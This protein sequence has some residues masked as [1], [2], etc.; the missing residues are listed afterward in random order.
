MSDCS[1]AEGPTADWPSASRRRASV[2]QRG[3]L[4]WLRAWSGAGAALVC[5]AVALTPT[6]RAQGASVE[7]L[8]AHCGGGLGLPPSLGVSEPLR[9]GG[10]ATLMARNL[11]A[12]SSGFLLTGWASDRWNSLPL[13]WSL[14]SVGMVGCDLR[15]RPDDIEPF[16]SPNS[17]AQWPLA[18]PNLPSL[19]G[20]HYYAQVLF[21]DPGANPAGFG[22]TPGLGMR[23]EPPFAV[24][25]LQS[26]V[27]KDGITFVFAQPTRVGRFVNGDWFTVGPAR[28][29]D[30]LP[31]ATNLAGRDLHGAMVDPAASV[32]AQGFDTH[33]YGAANAQHYQ[34]GLNRAL[35]VSAQTPLVLMPGH[36]LVKVES[37]PVPPGVAVLR[38]AA[39]LIALHEAPVEGAFRPPYAGTDHE[40][41]FHAGMVRWERLRTLAPAAGMPLPADV[42]AQLRGLWLDHCPSWVGRLMHPTENMPD[43]GRDLA[44][45]LG[46]AA[47]MANCAIP[48]GERRELILHL[49]QKG[50]DNHGALRAGG[51]WPGLGGH[52]SGRKLPILFAGQLLDDAGMLSIGA[53]HRSER[54]LDGTFSAYFGEDCQT[55]V[56]QQTAPGV[57]NWGHGGYTLADVGTADW[58]FS[59]V[60]S[61]QNDAAA[62]NG[63]SYR[64]CC[65]VNAWL[66]HVLTARMMGLVGAWNHQVLF[67]YTDRYMAIETVGWHRAWS[68]WVDAMWVRYRSQY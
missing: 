24:T 42:L 55:F 58:G 60:D 66:G 5:A 59:H 1:D 2:R 23:I 13:P 15:V 8:G 25:S 49:I 45:L 9:V 26:Q 28:I 56:V 29:V 68:P 47:L 36:S 6:V 18:V 17:Y 40:V 4:G 14:S 32:L 38:R 44:S 48:A 39:V 52:G 37:W 62:W 61:P 7:L 27:T 67:D 30:M 31:R 34:A 46:E 43:Y 53:T 51:R 41:R 22:A 65:T 57:V 63:S 54:R 19:Q 16:W 12:P 21:Q 11:G 50:I 64:V 10:T 3:V 20:L 33:L 35:G